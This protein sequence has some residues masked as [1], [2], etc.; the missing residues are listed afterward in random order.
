MKKDLWSLSKFI[1]NFMKKAQQEQ[2]E[3]VELAKKRLNE[4]VK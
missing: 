1:D 2:K 3:E 4:F